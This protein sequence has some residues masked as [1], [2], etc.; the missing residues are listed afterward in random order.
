MAF[1]FGTLVLFT[2]FTSRP[3][4]PIGCA[5][6]RYHARMSAIEAPANPT[7]VNS[8]EI[9]TLLVVLLAALGIR[10]YLAQTAEAVS[11][12][13]CRFVWFAQ[14]LAADGVS[15]VQHEDQH[16]LYPITILFVHGLLGALG[17]VSAG[18]IGW[19][20]AAIVSTCVASLACIVAMWALTRF[21]FGPCVA[22]VVALFIAVLPDFA[23]W[24]ADGLSDPLHLL[25]YIA[26][27]GFG[28]RALT[29]RSWVSFIAAGALS[30]LAFLTRPEGAGVALVIAP[31]CLFAGGGDRWRRRLV[32][33][34]LVIAA[35]AIFAGPYMATTGSIV[36]KKSLES[37]FHVQRTNA[38][39]RPPTAASIQASVASTDTVSAFGAI[40][41]I[42]QKW[43]R[44]CRVVYFV[45]GV[46]GAIA[47]FWPPRRR[48]A[49]ATITAA[50]A[51]HFAVLVLLVLNFSYGEEL[52]QR[53]TLVL[54]ALLLPWSAAGLDW[55][56][57]RVRAALPTANAGV[58][59]AIA[60]VATISPTL[61]WLV[62][63]RNPDTA[64]LIEAG[65]WLAQNRPK[66]ALVMSSEPRVAFYA[67]KSLKRW[68]AD[69]ARL[70]VLLAHIDEFRPDVVALDV[71]R[72]LS[73]N[74]AFLSELE[75]SPAAAE[76]LA[77]IDS[78]AGH[79]ESK[80]R[81]EILLFDAT[82]R[83][84]GPQPNQ[85]SSSG[86]NSSSD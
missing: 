36:N 53:H 6:G 61:P 60:L 74:P 3:A 5:S 50:G 51:L 79:D 26:A 59:W 83:P 11:R 78:F 9:A 62:R 33:A 31:A 40:V 4:A 12:D 39:A 48:A 21:L 28:V 1:P 27:L 29:N 64:H 75:A 58:V 52:S 47:V 41:V 82:P 17:L 76:R 66:A 44:T 46:V 77:R 8:R 80:H 37:L 14:Q 24:S 56:V 18:N 10:I 25:L 65:R 20:T 71:H 23:G 35:F 73:R 43:V 72:V 34:G 22:L 55:I 63:T 38:E 70:A 19:A 68:P 42:V 49:C 2:D 67:D 15:A 81:H 32:R 13:T 54:T 45:L 84:L 86:G 16:P 69:E 7:R 57:R 30:G 85:R